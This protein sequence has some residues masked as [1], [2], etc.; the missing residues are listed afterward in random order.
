MERAEKAEKAEKAKKA[1]NARKTDSAEKTQSAQGAQR[2]RRAEQTSKL[3]QTQVQIPAASGKRRGKRR[4]GRVQTAKK[5]PVTTHQK[6][7]TEQAS[8]MKPYY[9]S[10]HLHRKG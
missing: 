8:L 4:R 7:S 1:K 3:E 6:D 10:D 5:P 9:L 2:A